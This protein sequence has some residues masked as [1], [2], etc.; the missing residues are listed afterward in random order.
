MQCQEPPASLGNM[1]AEPIHRATVPY[2]ALRSVLPANTQQLQQ[3]PHTVYGGDS[4]NSQEAWLLSIAD[5]Y[6]DN[7][8]RI[9]LPLPDRVSGTCSPHWP[10]SKT[11]DPIRGEDC[12]GQT[13]GNAFLSP[14]PPL[15]ET[16]GLVPRITQ[17]W[18]S[19]LLA[20]EGHTG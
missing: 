18:L 8:S 1:V 12:Q 15:L 20:L 4:R 11:R 6:P 19:D 16:R 14:N 13:F 17:V 5:M 10:I 7:V 3:F 9:P 2:P